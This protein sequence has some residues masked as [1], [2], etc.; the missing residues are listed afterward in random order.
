[1]SVSLSLSP[2][3]RVCVYLSLVSLPLSL[4]PSLVSHRERERDRERERQTDRDRQ[5]QRE[6][7]TERQTNRQRD[8]EG[9][10]GGRQRIELMEGKRNSR[11]RRRRRR[12]KTTIY[13]A[14]RTSAR[15]RQQC[16]Q[17]E[18][19][20]G[21]LPFRL[22]RT[23]VV[24]WPDQREREKSIKSGAFFD[25][26]HCFSSAPLAASR[27]DP[28]FFKYF[29]AATNILLGSSRSRYAERQRR[30]SVCL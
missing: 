10:E 27:G 17:L 16:S 9:R 3:V 6:T 20:R 2:C 25:P 28:F 22:R 1:M 26:H 29:G 12:R 30:L 23:V 19:C 15:K 24:W 13:A 11:R 5:T 14:D 18:N 8:R 21:F 7:E 4:S